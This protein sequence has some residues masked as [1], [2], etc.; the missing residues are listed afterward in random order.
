ML[1][2]KWGGLMILQRGIFYRLEGREICPVKIHLP[3]KP[4]SRRQNLLIR[5]I[6]CS[7]YK[8]GGLTSTSNRPCLHKSL[9][10][11]HGC[12][13]VPIKI[14]LRGNLLKMIW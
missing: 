9:N 3:V 13:D 1:S 6:G 8:L 7:H 14:F 4:I 11:F 10:P 2:I 5:L 12:Y